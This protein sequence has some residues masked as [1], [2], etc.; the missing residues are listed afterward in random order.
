MS[1]YRLIR[2]DHF[3]T[4]RIPL[5]AGRTFHISETRAVIVSESLA[6]RLWD[7][8]YKLGSQLSLE[9]EKAP[10]E[11]IG[12]VADVRDEE[13][14]KS[15]W[16]QLYLPYSSPYRNTLAA[17]ATLNLIVRCQPECAPLLPALRRQF[18]E[19]GGPQAAFRIEAADQIVRRKLAPARLRALVFGAYS[20]IALCLALIGAF[21]LVS[22]IGVARRHEIGVH[23]A[24]GA[25]P[26]DVVWLLFSEGF[27]FAAIGVAGGTALALLASR[28]LRGL[29]FGVAPADTESLAVAAFC[30]LAGGAI[31]S[32]APALQ[33]SR[34]QPHDVLRQSS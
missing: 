18:I 4:L 34:L 27:R 29:V 3:Q 8:P 25:Q 6:K 13:L 20:L 16:P 23:V 9:G 12:V 28:F 1:S 24:L 5:L 32:V 19:A 26:A 31:A 14:D 10:R 33:V 30:L 11:V 21:A 15:P 2:G 22:Y 7:G 17:P